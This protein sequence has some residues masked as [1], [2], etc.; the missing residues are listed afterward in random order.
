MNSKGEVSIPFAHPVYVRSVLDCLNSRGVSPSTVL[1]N[2]GLAWQDIYDGQEMVDFSAFRRFVAQAIQCSG[3]PALGLMAGSMLQPY[4]SPVGIA[5]V[6]SD[7]LGQG[8]E[9]VSRH[10]NLLF[11][12]VE[13][14]I[15]SGPQWS[16]I[17]VRP[18]RP[19]C[20]THVFVM[21]STLEDHICVVALRHDSHPAIAQGARRRPERRI[22]RTRK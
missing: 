5:A 1:S 11:G 12:G 3:E 4:H 8:L 14:Q 16:T 2:A 21:Q 13:F 19:L 20:E 18:L 10:A 6:T 9:F 7:S 15:Q 17:K 22:S